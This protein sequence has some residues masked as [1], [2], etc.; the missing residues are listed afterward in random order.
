MTLKLGHASIDENGKISGGQVGDQ[1]GKEVCIRPYYMHSKGWYL[2]RPKSNEHANKIAEAMIRACNNNNIGYDQNGR[3]G[4]I[5]YGT[6]SSVKTECDCSS[7]VRQCVIEATG[8]DPG[9]FTTA[10][11]KTMLLATGLFED[12]I[13][14]TS[15]TVMYNGDIL[16]TK[17]K[18]HTAIIVEGNT[19]SSHQNL[20]KDN[21][22]K[23]TYNKSN[24]II[25]IGQNHANNFA[26][27][28]LEEDGIYG[29][30]T[31]Q[32]SIKVLQRAMN[33]DYNVRLEEDS[34]FGTLS[35]KALGKHY[36]KRG[37]VQYMVTALEILL[38]LKGYDPKGI[39]L[40]GKFGTELEKIV[41]Q[42]Q[43]DKGLPQ[44]G[45]CDSNTFKS[46]IS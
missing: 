14:V 24:P 10:N 29:N 31:K 45:I 42:Y 18:G 16:V 8:K 13:S 17:T 40:P 5:K 44:T 9:N 25:K 20:E 30:L 21:N 38:M 27:C 22:N 12:V 2:I 26:Q 37:E 46:L 6:N 23:I 43:K 33:L 7:L 32:A 34:V 28:G 15:S 3:L 19:R 11:E 1:T 4:V 39:E 36:V 41:K 35:N